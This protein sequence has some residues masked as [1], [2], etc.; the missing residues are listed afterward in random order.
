MPKP[1]V[2]SPYLSVP[3]RTHPYSADCRLKTED[4][5]SN[6]PVSFLIGSKSIAGKYF[7]WYIFLEKMFC[8]DILRI[9]YIKLTE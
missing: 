9:M 2:F 8:K 3:I 7:F 5:S 1:E 4:F 6:F